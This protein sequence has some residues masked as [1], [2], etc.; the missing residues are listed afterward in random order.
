[1]HTKK[2]V[3]STTEFKRIKYLLKSSSV[4]YLRIRSKRI[5]AISIFTRRPQTLVNVGRTRWSG[6]TFG[7][8][9]LERPRVRVATR[10][11]AA[12]LTRTEINTLASLSSKTGWAL[13]PKRER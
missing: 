2:L 5:L 1:M 12:W 9:A 7:T 4:Q 8:R 3:N 6:E 11:I 10:T 13:T